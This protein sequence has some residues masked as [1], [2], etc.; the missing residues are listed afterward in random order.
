M[1]AEMCISKIKMQVSG[2]EQAQQKHSALFSQ[3]NVSTYSAAKKPKITHMPSY[4][5]LAKGGVNF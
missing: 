4:S 1:E 5:K 2:I 3:A